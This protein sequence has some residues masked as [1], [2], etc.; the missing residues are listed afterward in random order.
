[1]SGLKEIRR[2][3][4]SVQN[5]K[6][7]TRAMKLVSAAK[8]RRA[9]DA[10]TGGKQYV[11]GLRSVMDQVVGCLPDGF[12]HPLLSQQK[13]A[14]TEVK[15]RRVIVI[16][17]ERGLCGPYNT[18]VF[19]DVTTCMEESP[20]VKHEFIVLGRR[21]VSYA[22]RAKWNVI[23]EYEGLEE[24]ASN[25]P[26]DEIGGLLIEDYKAGK[27]DEAKIF[28]T[29]FISAMVQKVQ[30][31]AILPFILPKSAASTSSEEQAES[32]A[33]YVKFSPNPEEIF[34]GLVPLVLKSQILQAGF[35]S[36]ASEHASRMTAMDAATN[37][38]N[39]LNDRLLLFYNRARQSAITKELL[40][41][42]GGA[43]AVQ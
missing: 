5:T 24:N 16:A 34:S 11:D 36:K 15:V 32:A 33:G 13:E 40:D 1:M 39:D 28:Y 6:Q 30:N 37:N 18:N 42:I 17:G 8:L 26:I 22:K 38:A 10:A 25:W 19:K 7:I 23:R 21:A 27:F 31:K 4:T 41:I 29:Q 35:D 43:E 9:Q 3:I 14:G 12:S 2:R 20:N